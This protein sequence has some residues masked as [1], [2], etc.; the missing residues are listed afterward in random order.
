MRLT[1]AVPFFSKPCENNDE[2]LAIDPAGLGYHPD[3]QSVLCI[4]LL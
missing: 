2:K 3:M 1:H 4:V